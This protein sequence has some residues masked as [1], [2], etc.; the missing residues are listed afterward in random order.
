MK[1][2]SIRAVYVGVFAVLIKDLFDRLYIALGFNG[3][4]MAKVA[5][6]TF[7]TTDQVSTTGGMIIGFAAHYTIGGI[8]GLLFLVLLIATGK[9]QNVQKGVFFGLAVWLFLAGMLLSFGISRYTPLSVSNK[10]MLLMDHAVFG[11]VLGILIPGIALEQYGIKH[12]IQGKL[13]PAY[14]L[15]TPRK[16]N[17]ED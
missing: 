9:K 7:I 4:N 13:Q 10:L 17:N 1:D 12:F 5:A 6:G 15:L 16:N 3:V 2:I 14:K 8:L 11:A